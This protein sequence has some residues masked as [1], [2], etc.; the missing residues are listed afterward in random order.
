MKP[1]RFRIPSLVAVLSSFLLWVPATQAQVVTV[2]DLARFL[3]GQPVSQA[4]PLNQLTGLPSVRRHYAN[5]ADLAKRWEDTRLKAIREW[6]RTEIQPKLTRPDS[7]NYMFG[8]PDFVHVVSIFPRAPE[9]ILVGLEP[10]GSLPDFLATSEAQLDSYLSHL[11]HSLRSISMRNFFITTEMREDFGGDGVDGVFPV[12]LYFAALTNHHVVEANYVKLASSGEAVLAQ[13]GDA[14]GV[15]LRLREREP[16]GGVASDMN[17]YYFRTDLS[18]S[19]FKA[20]S[21][22]HQFLSARQGNNV[23]YLKAASYLMHT[24]NFTNIRN[25]L[26][27]SCRFLLQD[28][29]GIPAE[30][31]S[32]YYNL[33]FY[34]NYVGPI[35]TFAEHDQPFLH[36][37]YRSGVAKPLPFGTGYRMKDTD[38]IQIFGVRK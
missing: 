20:G 14:T 19:G 8:G 29:S 36:Q 28:E 11:S 33:D 35:D 25:F 5:T 13:G 15:W 10:L 23:G 27:S 21:P 24:E 16:V 34:G 1:I 30:F 22:F 12:L 18:D 17:L 7:V 37:A 38:S 4:S 31:L 32:L 9:Y 3:A 6:G 2:D 26:V